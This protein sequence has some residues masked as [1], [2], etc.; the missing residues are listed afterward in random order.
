MQVTALANSYCV[1]E[2]LRG[3]KRSAKMFQISSNV[4]E[5]LI[6]NILTGKGVE[7]TFDRPLEEA[8][9]HQVRKQ[10]EYRA[11]GQALGIEA[12]DVPYLVLAFDKRVPL[13]TVDIRSLY[14]FRKEIREKLGILVTSPKEFVESLS[15]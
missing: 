15:P 8:I 5:S 1:L 14:D 13:I 2:I 7:L 12:K 4:I 10:A 3:A 9:L 11:L 6:W